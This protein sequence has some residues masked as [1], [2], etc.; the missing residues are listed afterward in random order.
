MYSAIRK[1]KKKRNLWAG[2]MPVI[3]VVVMVGACG[4][5]TYLQHGHYP[6]MNECLSQ[7]EDDY[8]VLFEDT[9]Y[10]DGY[11]PPLMVAQRY[12]I[13]CKED[14]KKWRMARAGFRKTI[15]RL[16]SWVPGRSRHTGEPEHNAVDEC[17]L[18]HNEEIMSLAKWCSDEMC[19][20]GVFF[21]CN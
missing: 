5:S 3:V 20:V 7:H 19:Y 18:L 21:P 9:T 8:S 16:I 14:K 12:V 6:C 15:F 17:A 4:G 13:A 1:K 10:T 11:S 2:L